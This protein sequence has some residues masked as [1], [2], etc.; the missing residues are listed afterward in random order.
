VRTNSHPFSEVLL[1]MPRSGDHFEHFRPH[2]RH[3]HLILKEYFSAWGHKLGL[4]NGAGDVILYVDACAGRGADDLGNQGSPLIAAVAA[5]AAAANISQRRQRPFGIHVLA[6]ESNRSHASQLADV[7]A[8]FGSTVRVLPG[9]LEEHLGSILSE[10]ADTPALFFIDPFGLEPLKAELIRA[11]LDGDR[12]EALLLFADQAALRHFGAIIAEDTR[13]ERRYRSA[14]T[15][16]PLFPDLT[17][18]NAGALAQA[19]S[20]SRAQLEITR[21]NALRIMNAAF[22]NEHWLPKLEAV[23]SADRRVA[24]LRLYTERLIEWGA[25]YVLPIP[26][27]D[28][29]GTH[30]YTLIHAAK[31]AKGYAA[32]KEAVAYALRHSPLPEAVVHR[33]RF[34]VASDLDSVEASVRDRFAGQTVRWAEDASNRTAACV[35]NFLL[36]ETPAFPFEFDELK[37]RLNDHRNRGRVI[38]FSLPERS[39]HVD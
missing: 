6:I 35:R 19:A 20:Q 39:P 23:P 17:P 21:E 7:L 4:R 5:G 34:A 36:E 11:A 1:I 31:S 3:K 18:I 15:A 14:T 28:A 16:L 30:A 26:V 38:T 10:Y 27:V 12:R 37:A 22:G 13:A 24:F 9:T 8:P 33:M 29:T 32:M 2:T 25:R